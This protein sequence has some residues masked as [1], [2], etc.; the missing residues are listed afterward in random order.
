MTAVLVLAILV[1]GLAVVA[2]QRRETRLKR[3]LALF[4]NRAH[5]NLYIRLHG[6]S[7]PVGISPRLSLK[8]GATAPLEEVI[9]QI[10]LFTNR[11]TTRLRSSFPIEIDSAGLAESGQS[12]TSLVRLPPRRA[13]AF[14]STNSCSASSSR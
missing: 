12:L 10:K 9:S 4:R 5:Q 1:L 11:R 14:L 13:R 8:W 6:P 3:A 7:P 2:Q